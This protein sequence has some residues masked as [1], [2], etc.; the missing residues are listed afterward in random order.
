[1]GI[2]RADPDAQ[3]SAD[4]VFGTNRPR[5]KIAFMSGYMENAFVH[6]GRLDAGALLLSKPFRKSGL[7]QIV[8]QALDA[9][10]GSARAMPE[11]A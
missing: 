8:H 7:A 2:S 6:D 3:A 9:A 5:T 1:M 4:E 10:A 11:A